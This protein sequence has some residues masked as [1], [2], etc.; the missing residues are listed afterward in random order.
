MVIKRSR[1]Q[2]S[3]NK[4]HKQPTMQSIQ[5]QQQKR[6]V[7][8]CHG[9]SFI[10]LNNLFMKICQ[11]TLQTTREWAKNDNQKNGRKG[12]RK[13]YRIVLFY[14]F[15][16]GVSHFR[17]FFAFWYGNGFCDEYGWTNFIG[18]KWSLV[19]FWI[20]EKRWIGRI[21]N[22]RSINILYINWA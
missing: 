15:S 13:I 22:P 14:S 7:W 12:D 8:S 2:S 5:K 17:L 9:I 19:W 3:H 4:G 11:E 18:T 1:F 21:V 20:S 16:L 6:S 10:C